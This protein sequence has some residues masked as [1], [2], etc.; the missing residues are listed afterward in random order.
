MDFTRDEGQDAV[1]EVVVGLLEREPARDMGLWP[2]LV[3]TGLLGLALP[4]R[5]G[6]DGMGQAEISVLLTELAT[7]A[8][9]VPALPTL[10][11]GLLPLLPV[12]PDAVAEVVYPEVGKGAVLTAALS[13]PG[14][15]F[16]T[17][18]KT[19]AVADGGVVRV[20]G[21]K[22]AVPYA[23]EARWLLIPTDAG[24]ALVDGDAEGLTRT[25]SPA[26][27]GLPECT[28]RLADVAIPAERLLPGDL[29]DLHRY[30]VSAI[31]SV[32]DGLLK[33]ALTLTAEHLRTRRQFGRPLA[34]FQAV[35]QE[36]ADLYVVSRTLHAVA[37]SA[38]W[39]LVQEE[40]DADHRARV[41]DDLDVLAYTVAAE[42]PAAM[43]KCHHLH[44]GLGVDITHPM[45][46]Y[47]SQA[48]D[49]ARWLGGESLRLDRLGARCSSI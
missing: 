9:A 39:A 34:E 37:V 40:G 36:V 5:F 25:A 22:I 35:A 49:L 17:S 20:S 28:V 8:V 11:F 44:G 13:E 14:R 30:A 27:G 33:G 48:K 41:D 38:S 26:S 7:D 6:G 43:Q 18:P 10:G 3:E 29:A 1:A 45:H 32:A 46:R 47:Y 31:G 4:E 19:T 42:L 12:L 16:T 24:I 2:S 15:P 21:H 23:E